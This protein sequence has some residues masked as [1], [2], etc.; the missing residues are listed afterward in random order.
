MIKYSVPIILIDENI[1][2]ELSLNVQFSKYYK[3]L[4]GGVL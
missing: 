4:P 2:L 3:Q 1:N